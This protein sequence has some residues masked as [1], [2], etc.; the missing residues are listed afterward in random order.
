ML[1]RGIG[2]VQRA[3]LGKLGLTG[4]LDDV[5][6]SHEVGASKADGSLFAAAESR[7]RAREFV[8]VS[9]HPADVDHAANAG[10]HAVLAEPDDLR[11][12]ITGWLRGHR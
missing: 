3:K 5:V 4:V 11:E 1:T 8:Y 9:T 7:L 2:R 6:V 12:S 10:W